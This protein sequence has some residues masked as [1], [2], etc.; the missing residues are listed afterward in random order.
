MGDEEPRTEPATEQ[1]P[2]ESASGEARQSIMKDAA[3]A[4][5][6]VS[7]EAA[8]VKTPH[9][10]LSRDG[11]ARADYIRE[12]VVTSEGN[13]VHALQNMLRLRDRMLADRE[14][15]GVTAEQVDCLF[16][17][18]QGILSLHQTM[19]EEMKA[20]GDVD[21]VFLSHCPNGF[22]VYLPYV[23]NF[24]RANELCEK[25]CS[26]DTF[27]AYLQT[28]L[29]TLPPP[30][31]THLPSYLVQPVQRVPRYGLF[32]QAL[33]HN[34]PAGG[35]TTR[36][37]QALD[38]VKEICTKQNTEL[39]LHILV[40]DRSRSTTPSL[41]AEK[42]Q[43]MLHARTLSCRDITVTQDLTTRSRPRERVVKPRPQSHSAD[44][45]EHRAVA[46]KPP[47]R[48]PPPQ[49]TH[50]SPPQSRRAPSPLTGSPL[51][52]RAT[53][54]QAV[55]ARTAVTARPHSASAA[56]PPPPPP[57]LPRHLVA[58]S[59]SPKPERTRTLLR[60]VSLPHATPFA[61]PLTP[62]SYTVVHHASL[63]SIS[64]S[65]PPAPPP[66]LRP[67]FVVGGYHSAR[68]HSSSPTPASPSA[69]HSNSRFVPSC[70]HIE[71]FPWLIPR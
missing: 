58:R 15:C 49:H 61:I 29:G 3:T 40:R 31:L 23:S 18:V 57:P 26:N 20:H 45:P 65:P 41:S 9:S 59:S 37:K 44:A 56:S 51:R 21:G 67:P 27:P 10:P 64:R 55:T 70:V 62:T 25:L 63:D 6:P 39:A 7:H 42:K 68:G 69:E 50:T 19:H 24:A 52:A 34:I 30:V 35:D 8:A 5:V 2:V 66:L 54:P 47:S 46:K 17:H 33:L 38:C 4:P 43:G 14:I 22:D 28:I 60:T 32:F 13:F 16:G 36:L 11:D 48:G 1:V 71:V 53:V 12:E